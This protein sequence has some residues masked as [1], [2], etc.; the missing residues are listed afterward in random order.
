M[1]AVLDAHIDVLTTLCIMLAL[2][3]ALTALKLRSGNV[4]Y[5]PKSKGSLKG[6][7]SREQRHGDDDSS[8]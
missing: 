5:K 7:Y 6:S 4:D 2:L 8:Q 3:V 1:Y